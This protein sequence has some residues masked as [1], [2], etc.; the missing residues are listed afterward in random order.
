MA[1]AR[2]GIF[3]EKNGKWRIKSQVTIDGETFHIHKRGFDTENEAYWEK[4][5]LEQEIREQ[6]Q[7]MGVPS[8]ERV[9]SDY[10]AYKKGQQRDTTIH[11]HRLM[12][13]NH[14]R[15]YNKTPV[16][17]IATFE[18]LKEIVNSIE[19]KELSLS[20][21]N[22]LIRI[23]KNILLYSYNRNLLKDEHRKNIQMI[24]VPLKEKNIKVKKP[25]KILT[26]E[27]YQAFLDVIPDKSIDKMLFTLWGQTGLRIGEIRALQ[28]VHLDRENCLIIIRQQALGKMG[29][30]KTIIGPPKTIKSNRSISITPSLMNDLF[31]MIDIL[32][33][34]DNQFLFHVRSKNIPYSENQIR[35]K[36]KKY[37][38]LANVTYIKPHGIRH[39]NTS[40]LLSNIKD[41][42]EIGLVSERLG[43]SSKQMTLDIYF[44]IHKKTDSDLLKIVDF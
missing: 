38:E 11:L 43:H 31:E 12:I 28:P 13:K 30:G 9:A 24:L 35:R 41:L 2:P 8:F 23:L 26:K 15:K 40:W 1:R 14:L 37:S 34:K 17:K 42:S 20:N 19:K 25:I 39:S 21:K 18:K 22:A 3:K 16:A 32:E 27:E 36:Q 4:I 6:G 7:L 5:R 33:I 44:H 10:F 29:K